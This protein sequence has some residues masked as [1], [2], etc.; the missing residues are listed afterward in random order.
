M[1]KKRNLLSVFYDRDADVLYVSQGEPSSQDETSE[2]VD[3]VVVRRDPE[4][5]EVKGFT[6]LNF[7]KRGLNKSSHISLPFQIALK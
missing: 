4:A 5:K 7:L 6:I 1:K 2:T 3:E